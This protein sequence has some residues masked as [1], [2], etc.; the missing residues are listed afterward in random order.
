V[1]DLRS[2][3]YRIFGVDLTNVPGI[4]AMTSQTIL[5][6]VG[7]DVSPSAM[8]PR[9]PLGSACARKRRSAAEKCS[10][11]RADQSEAGFPSHFVWRHV[12]YTMPKTT[13]ENSSA[14]YAASSENLKLSQVQFTSLPES[15]TT[16]SALERRVTNP[17]STSAR[18]RH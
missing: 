7:T 4:S 16:C 13:W 2:E 12:L 14:G 5:R 11:P 3:L 8:H 6:E 17:C 10:S 1:F 9:S 18:R 15:S